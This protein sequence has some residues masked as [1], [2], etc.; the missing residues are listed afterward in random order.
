MSKR[1]VELIDEIMEKVLALREE[2]GPVRTEHSRSL[3]SIL[4]TLR[5]LK[6][7]NNEG[8]T[9]SE[10]Y[11]I[12]CRY[13]TYSK[14]VY[15]S[16]ERA[17]ALYKHAIGHIMIG[18]TMQDLVQELTLGGCTDTELEVLKAVPVNAIRTSFL[19][20]A[21]SRISTKT[22]LNMFEAN[23]AFGRGNTAPV[24][25]ARD[26]T[27]L[28]EDLLRPYVFYKLF[29]KNTPQ[30]AYSVIKLYYGDNI[31][32]EYIRNGVLI[33]N[34]IFYFDLA[35]EAIFQYLNVKLKTLGVK[36]CHKLNN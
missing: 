26:T 29:I 19:H 4:V 24:T 14:N 27:T 17:I 21:V 31:P 33:S 28:P 18:G 35:V 5:K 32:E 30:N 13:L 7:E 3:G 11:N 2:L 6:G 1:A 12:S 25:R 36:S 34:P 20:T 10:M 15:V 22:Q 16:L 8:V 23:Q 9:V